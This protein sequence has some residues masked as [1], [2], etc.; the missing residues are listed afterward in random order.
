[1][2]R[3]AGPDRFAKQYDALASRADHWD[4][5]KRIAAPTLLLWGEDDPYVSVA[6]GRRM[7]DAIPTAQ[8]VTLSGCRH[9][10]TLEQP[11][12]TIGAARTWLAAALSALDS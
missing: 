4:D 12:A 2:G 5:L 11:E 9:F 1:M 8:L 10:P 7:V 3:T 6:V